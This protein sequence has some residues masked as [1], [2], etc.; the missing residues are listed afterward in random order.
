ML[1][2][3][4][5]NCLKGKM[6]IEARILNIREQR[7]KKSMSPPHPFDI[8]AKYFFCILLQSDF[9]FGQSSCRCFKN[10]SLQYLLPLKDFPPTLAPLCFKFHLK[11]QYWR[12][13]HFWPDTGGRLCFQIIWVISI[14]PFIVTEELE[15]QRPPEMNVDV[16]TSK[17]CF[18]H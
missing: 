6:V 13:C 10:W 5:A 15:S 11:K 3:S 12:G 17:L 7:W 9:F 1:A 18:N 16:H 2:W 8:G 4:L 14:P